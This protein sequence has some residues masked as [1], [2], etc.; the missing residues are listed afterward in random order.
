MSF[1]F[2]KTSFILSTKSPL[3]DA[4]KSLGRW[5]KFAQE[6]DKSWNSDEYAVL[7]EMLNVSPPIG[8]KA[9]KLYS[10]TQTYQFNRDVIDQ[11]SKIDIDNPI[12][13]ATIS[14]TEAAKKR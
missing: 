5:A 6:Q 9:R 11:M 12:Y 2:C 3:K 14:A 10:A 7:M 1:S 13:D 4:Y 8:I